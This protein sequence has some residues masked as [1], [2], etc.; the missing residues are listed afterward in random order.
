MAMR[1]SLLAVL[2]LALAAAISVT[3][4]TLAGDRTGDDRAPAGADRRDA[5]FSR[6]ADRGAR[7]DGHHRHRGHHRHGMHARM[8]AS[9][10]ERLNVTPQRLRAAAHT[11]K[12]RHRDERSRGAMTPARLA[13]LKGELAAELGAE[14]GKPPD[15]I[16]TA[17]RAELSEKLDKAVAIGMLSERARDMAL[18]CFDRPAECDLRALRWEAGLGKFRHGRR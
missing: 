13:A 8:L 11:V 16:L 7:R 5:A 12:E 2:V 3:A 10:A 14:L 1:K 17:V 18:A 15:E 6:I 4:V 9:L